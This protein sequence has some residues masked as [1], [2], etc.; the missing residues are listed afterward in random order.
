VLLRGDIM[1]RATLLGSPF[2]FWLV[3]VYWV[4]LVLLGL[5]P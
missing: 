1:G 5:L 2:L 3:F 4:W